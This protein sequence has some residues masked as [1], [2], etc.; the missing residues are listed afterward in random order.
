MRGGPPF[1][2]VDPSRGGLT[3]R[4]IM[5]PLFMGA[6]GFMISMSLVCF[7]AWE[8]RQEDNKRIDHLIQTEAKEI[9]TLIQLDLRARLTAITRMADRWVASGGTERSVFQTDAENYVQ[10]M[11]GFQAIEWV[12]PDFVVKWIVPL[13]GNEAAVD[14]NLAQEE[15][16]RLALEAAR[17]NRG[18]TMTKPID[19]VQGGKGFLT[20]SPLF[21]GER[22]DGF[23][24]SVFRYRTWLEHAMAQDNRTELLGETPQFA[25]SVHFAG[26]TVLEMGGVASPNASPPAVASASVAGVEFSVAVQPTEQLLSNQVSVLPIVILFGGGSLAAMVGITIFLL[27]MSQASTQ[28]AQVNEDRFRRVFDSSASGIALHDLSGRYLLVNDRFCELTGYSREELAHMNWRDLTHPDDIA[29]TEAEDNTVLN[30][31]QDRFTIEKRYIRK[32][33]SVLW[34]HLSSTHLR[35]PEGRFNQILGSIADISERK[36]YEAKVMSTQ[37]ALEETVR[38]LQAAHRQ[39]ESE[40]ARKTALSEELATARDTAEAANNAK[41][42]FLAAMSHEIRTPMTGVMGFADLLLNDNLTKESSEKVRRIKESTQS[43]LMIINDILDMS[44]L[45]AG[46]MEIE[47][48]D[49]HAP[50]LIRD[51]LDIFR[52]R[53]GGD[54]KKVDLS[55]HIDDDFPKGINA[56]PTR[57]RQILVNLIGNAVKFTGEGEISVSATLEDAEDAAPALRIAVTDTGIGIPPETLDK[58]FSQFTQAD[59]SITRRFE[60]SGLGLSICKRLIDLMGGDIGVESKVGQGSTFWFTLPH[61]PARSTVSETL[62]GVSHRD[63]KYEIARPIKILVAEDNAV[64][65]HLIDTFFTN[66]GHNVDVAE[67]GLKAVEAHK[68]GSYEVILMDVR[69]PEMGGPEATRLIRRLEGDK[70]GIPII[71]LTAD[72]MDNHMQEYIQAGM[73]ACVAKPID[74][75]ELVSTINSVL[76]EPVH[77]ILLVQPDEEVQEEPEVGPEDTG[78]FDDLLAELNALGG[79]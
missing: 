34:A 39:I 75:T 57:V 33:G 19:L 49:F 25:M 26:E 10:D 59:A 42:E 58:L 54:G 43:L 56:D 62:S 6:L 22:F 47:R 48:I 9:T 27:L 67:N 21:L 73:D 74:W 40:V 55:L 8:V 12:N 16:R 13:A 61:I 50:S 76:D 30:R 41:S 28:A 3:K 66:L 20:Y 46:K 44:K 79:D 23:I 1:M 60:G 17:D 18:L 15:R 70:S 69:M 51:T 14:L 45:E 63:D 78:Q 52:E 7:F 65:Q 35:D 29:T 37:A 64:N 32:D 36:E 71:A 53:L 2:H 77:T 24:L 5:Q 72:A 4:R 31:T 68:A 11:I 38:N